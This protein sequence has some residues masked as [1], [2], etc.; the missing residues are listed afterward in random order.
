[1]SHFPPN[2]AGVYYMSAGAREFTNDWYDPQYYRKSPSIDPTGP[3]TG[4][5]RVV[6]GYFGNFESAMT[7]KRWNNKL[8]ELTG[9]WTLNGRERGG[10]TREIPHTKY[11]DYSGDASRCALN[12][13]S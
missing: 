5:Y 7:F 10:E 6:R 11:S 4:T 8:D 13:D 2:Q 1:M 9:T 3:T 12:Q